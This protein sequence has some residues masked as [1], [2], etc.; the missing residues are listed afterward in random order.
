M[1][2]YSCILTDSIN[3]ILQK[4][5]L[6]IS[7]LDGLMVQLLSRKQTLKEASLSYHLAMGPAIIYTPDYRCFR[8]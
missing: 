7:V 4:G 5:D 1:A 6:A 2:N 3:N 8:R